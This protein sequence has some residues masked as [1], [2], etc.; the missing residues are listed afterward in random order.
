V[1]DRV[2]AAKSNNSETKIHIPGCL[3]TPPQHSCPPKYTGTNPV[4]VRSAQHYFRSTRQVNGNP[5]SRQSDIAV[6]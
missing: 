4:D 2:S 3:R 6:E 1:A 5:T